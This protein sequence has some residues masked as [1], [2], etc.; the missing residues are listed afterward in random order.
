MNRFSKKNLFS[1]F[2]ERKKNKNTKTKMINRRSPPEVLLRKGVLKR[3]SKFTGEHPCVSEIYF[4]LKN[5]I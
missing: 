1:F 3:C 5:E 4:I 2:K